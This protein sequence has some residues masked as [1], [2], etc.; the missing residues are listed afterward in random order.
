MGDSAASGQVRRGT[1]MSPRVRGGM[2]ATPFLRALAVVMTALA[3]VP[4]GAHL[5]ALPNKIALPQ[6][7]Y[8]VAQGLYRGWALAGV[9]WFAAPL[10]DAVLALALRREGRPWR[11]AFAAALLMVAA[12]ALF[13]LFTFPANQATANW[14]EAPEGWEALRQQW[15]WSHAVNAVLVFLAL[16]CVTRAAV[17]ADRR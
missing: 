12:L 14:T 8:F 4:A 9:V 13:F 7:E 15:E 3:L 16:L 17:E 5:L 1:S 11:L 6:A 2:R 10:A